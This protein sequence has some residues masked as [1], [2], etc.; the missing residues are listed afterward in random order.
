MR[1]FQQT[2]NA[3]RA[4]GAAPTDRIA[5]RYAQDKP[6]TSNFI[7]KESGITRE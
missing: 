7:V 6:F 5:D 4:Q 1:D 2:P 3:H